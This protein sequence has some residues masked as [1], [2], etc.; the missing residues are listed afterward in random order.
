MVVKNKV[1]IKSLLLNFITLKGNKFKS[2][3]LL[4]TSLR[5]LQKSTSKNS[6]SILKLSLRNISP[7]VDTIKIKRRKTV[8]LVPFFLK[9][10][11]RLSH[12][13]KLIIKN[14]KSNNSKFSFGLSKE[15]I[16][17]SNNKGFVKNK[18]LNLHS[19]SF[20]NKNFSHFRW[21]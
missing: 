20:V 3:K 17:S 18:V 12:A 6:K 2:E 1:N 14:S 11:K 15:V 4:D 21:F 13:I 7:I 5:E 16:D 9:K 8:T 19:M 10:D